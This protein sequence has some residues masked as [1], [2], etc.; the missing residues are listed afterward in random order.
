MT[1]LKDKKIVSQH[2][3]GIRLQNW[4]SSTQTEMMAILL[5]LKTVRDTG[6]NKVIFTDSLAALHSLNA[7][8][9]AYPRLMIEVR[10]K[11]EAN[12]RL[13]N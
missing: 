12:L 6:N 2:E 9:S 1:L 10:R 11:T 4:A 13:G 8:N 3:V 5:A 7:D